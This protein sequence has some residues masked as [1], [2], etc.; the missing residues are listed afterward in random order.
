MIAV[1]GAD[2]NNSVLFD[3]KRHENGSCGGLPVIITNYL[4][5][6][7]YRRLILKMKMTSNLK[8]NNTMHHLMLDPDLVSKVT[9]DNGL[10]VTLQIPTRRDP[11][12]WEENDLSLRLAVN[13]V[14]ELIE[15][16]RAPE[17]LKKDLSNKVNVLYESVDPKQALDGMGMYVSAELS[18][19]LR[20]PFTVKKEVEVGKYFKFRNVF[21]LQQYTEP[22]KIL[23]LSKKMI[24]LFSAVGN[25]LV[26][27]KNEDFPLLY[28]EEYEYSRPALGNS[29][30]YTMKSFEKDKSLMQSQRMNAFIR[31]ADAQVQKY[32][33]G[34]GQKAILAGSAELLHEFQPSNPELIMG[35]VTGSFTD[36]NMH[37]LAENA[38][39]AVKEHKDANINALIGTIRELRNRALVISGADDSYAV[40]KEG[41]AQFLLVDKNY[42]YY[43]SNDEKHDLVDNIITTV[44]EKNGEVMFAEPGALKEYDHLV[45]KLRY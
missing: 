20:F 27:E 43:V 28:N 17:K 30:G 16:A 33:S 34:T 13:E 40:A 9:K 42:H 25:V 5:P 14:T 29:Y 12:A 41:R 4:F 32:I 3:I 24:R 36:R 31:S 23:L 45:M 19:L 2:I 38:W 37:V 44:L 6:T 35:S 21:Y 18:A 11:S 8:N 39:Y 7:F 1:I 15:K 22:Y 26:E 10:C